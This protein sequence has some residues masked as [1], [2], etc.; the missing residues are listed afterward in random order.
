M[1][2]ILL[3]DV[4]K[5]GRKGE[6]KEVN[7]GYANNLLLPKGL[8]K[9][10]T[11]GAIVAQQKSQQADQE[12]KS[13]QEAQIIESLK[14]V[15]KKEVTVYAHANEQGHLFS[16]IDSKQVLEAVKNDI[17]VVIDE[18]Y[19]KLPH[20]KEIGKHEVDANYGEV[21]VRFI[22]VVEADNK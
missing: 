2:V 11:P 10:A 22:V 3:K 9:I 4:P 19:I 6:V 14:M 17:E 8:A 21:S 1:K 16:A 20:I 5:I 12:A 7:Q 15:N 13:A 18:K